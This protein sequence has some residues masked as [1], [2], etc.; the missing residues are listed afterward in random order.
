MGEKVHLTTWGAA[1]K[2][3]CWCRLNP[4]EEVPDI[5]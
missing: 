3:G 2:E 1:I 4:D 5:L